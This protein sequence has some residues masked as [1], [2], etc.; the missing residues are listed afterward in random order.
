LKR[1]VERDQHR[2]SNDRVF[3][4]NVIEPVFWNGVSGFV[5]AFILQI[6]G[7]DAL[8]SRDA[9]ELFPNIPTV[10]EY[11]P[12]A[13]KGTPVEIIGR[14]N[15]VINAGP[16]DPKFKAALAGHGSDH[17]RELARGVWEAHG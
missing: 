13:P 2:G 11:V 15:K 6:P 8:T 12:G 14:L 16:A 7:C 10:G 9:L 4:H 1:D 3:E 5:I 17:A